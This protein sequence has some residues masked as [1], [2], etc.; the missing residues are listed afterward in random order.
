[1]LTTQMEG[2]YTVEFNMNMQ[3]VITSQQHVE[4][5]VCSEVQGAGT[6]LKPV[7]SVIITSSS[8]WTHSHPAC[9]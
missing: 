5:E 9:L 8:H 1:M 6:T 3:N 4:I 2:V 7:T